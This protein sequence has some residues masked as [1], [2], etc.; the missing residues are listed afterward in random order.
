MKLLRPLDDRMLCLVLGWE[1]ECAR[2]S[3]KICGRRG[4]NEE[5]EKKIGRRDR[6]SC[7]YQVRRARTH[8]RVDR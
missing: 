8:V 5:I 2:Q 7:M 1:G 4:R 3:E 6:R